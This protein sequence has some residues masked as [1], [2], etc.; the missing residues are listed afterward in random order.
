MRNALITGSMV[1]AMALAAGAENWPQFHGPDR[2]NV[3]PETGL[4]RS[5][6]ADGAKVLWTVEVGKGYGGAAIYDGKVYILDR[7]DQ[8]GEALRVFDVE[9]GKELWNHSYPA[10]GRVSH[11]GS[12]STPMVDDKHIITVGRLGHVH[13]FDKSTQ[14][15]VWTKN[16]MTDFGTGRVPRWGV[17]QSPLPYRDDAVIL[18]PQTGEAGLVCLERATGKEIWRSEPLAKMEYVSPRLITLGGVE[19][20]LMISGSKVVCGVE[21]ATGKVLWR[22]T[23]WF[24]KW[25]IPNATPIGDGRVFITGGYK[26]GSAMIKVTRSGESFEASELWK[27]DE[28]NS[29]MNPAMLIDGYLYANSNSNSA[30]DGMICMDLDGKVVWKTGRKANF[31]R[32]HMM[33]ADG[34]IW[35]IDGKRGSLHLIEP[36]P[37]EYKELASTKPLLGG[38][39]IWAP[40]ALSEGKLVIRDQHKMI[41]LDV[42][43]K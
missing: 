24:C 10:G 1:L 27:S 39:E 15:V 6:P 3:S 7:P 11:E 9:S 33:V 20:V 8:R 26:A 29:Q 14:K 5:F 22:Y 40:L 37:K 4:I 35:I 43:A 30:R 21:A 25:P 38:R 42:E 2:K 16:L 23:G 12:R 28:C 32:G 41:C 19:Q 34:M 36:S 31:E 17:A 13:C 18:A